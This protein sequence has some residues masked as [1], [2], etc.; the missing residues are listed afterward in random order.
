MI[1]R[2]ADRM[3]RTETAIERTVTARTLSGEQ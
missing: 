2:F 1:G 3:N